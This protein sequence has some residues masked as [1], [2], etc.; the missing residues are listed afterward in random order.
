MRFGGVDLPNALSDA[1]AKGELVIFAG[2]GVSMASPSD[3]PDFPTLANDLANG[4]ATLRQD[5]DVD[6]F[7]GKL[8]ENLNIYERTRLRLSDPSSKPNSL[9][10]DLLRVFSGHTSVRLVTT[11][12][13]DHF[14][15]A[16]VEVFSG[17]CPELFYAPALPVGNNFNGIVH[18]HGSTRKDPRR[19]VL[20]DKDFGRAYLT[21]GWA[22]RFIQDL[23]LS[24]TV[25]FVGY[26]HNDP[27]M[28]YLAR[29]LPPSEFGRRRFAL[30][31]DEPGSRSSWGN[32][33][34][35]PIPYS[36][37]DGHMQLREACTKWAELVIATPLE[38]LQ[39][40]REIVS[41]PPQPAGED[42][43][44]IETALTDV[45][46]LRF[47]K[48]HAS[49]VAWLE[50]VSGRDTFKQLFN[51]E[52]KA[53]K[54]HQELAHWFAHRFCVAHAAIALDIVRRNGSTL[55]PTLW[56]EIARQ[57]WMG[58]K[59]GDSASCLDRWVP[60]LI[61]NQPSRGS[62]FLEYILSECRL[63]EDSASAILL[64]SHLVRPVI[65]LTSGIPT[66]K[67]GPDGIT[68][69]EEPRVMIE[70]ES[71]GDHTFLEAAW[72]RFVS[73]DFSKHVHQL[74]SIVV[75]HLEEATHLFRSYG[76][77]H[78]WWDPISIHLPD[79]ETPNIVLSHS[80]LAVL[81]KAALDS[82][83]WI[84]QKEP[85]CGTALILWWSRGQSITLR[86]IALLSVALTSEWTAD[87]KL[88]WL[89]S[90][91]LI[92]QP[93]FYA[94]VPQVLEAA[95]PG[96]AAEVQQ[97]VVD[98]IMEGPPQDIEPLHKQH[99]I[100]SLLSRLNACCPD[101]SGVADALT[102]IARAHPELRPPEA[103]IEIKGG[104]YLRGEPPWVT[105][106]FSTTSLLAL[107]AAEA[108]DQVLAFEPD[109]TR[110]IG[111][112]DVV[113]I[114]QRAAEAEPKWGI[115][116][117]SLLQQRGIF[118]TY[119]WRGIIAGLAQTEVR[120]E[121]WSVVLNLLASHPGIAEV[122][123]YEVAHLLEQG[124]SRESGGIPH[125]ELQLAAAV[126]RLVWNGLTPRKWPEAQSDDW[127]FTAINDP[128]GIIMQFEIRA[129]NRLWK[130]AGDGW[131]GI[132]AD[133]RSHWQNVIRDDSWTSAM[134]RT[135]LASQVHV[136]FAMDQDWTSAEMPDVFAWDGR[137][138]AAEQAW[139]G[140]LGWGRWSDEFLKCFLS[141]YTATFPYL[142]SNLGKHRARFCEH[143][144]SIAV[145]GAKNPLSDGWLSDFIRTVDDEDRA[146]W[147][148]SVEMALRQVPSD[149]KQFVWDKWMKTYWALRNQGQPL[150]PS[151]LEVSLMTHWLLSLGSAMPEAL[152]LL[153]Q[154]PK[155]VPRDNYANS[156]LYMR[157]NELRIDA[158]YPQEVA[159]F[160]RYLLNSETGAPYLD[161]INAVV[162]RLVASVADR[163]VL[164]QVCERLSVLG[165]PT[166]A[167]ELKRLVEPSTG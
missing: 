96:A 80:G 17:S 114:L 142:R 86:R 23:F 3:L 85:D 128:A 163:T 56:S 9:H 40:V 103:L 79:L 84:V 130:G 24:F 164:I 129:L 48:E 138:V 101:H 95:F 62:D 77:E 99:R 35:H 65:T 67:L 36:A 116:I 154:G 83:K 58:M 127:L 8:P 135:L 27:V 44:L 93:G 143:I 29:G 98:R 136:L 108:L 166:E 74:I 140:Y 69:L 123:T 66:E 152:Q 20:T 92:Y 2:A 159:L 147:A 5:E 149:K 162:R 125:E 132:P 16:A 25:L 133:W 39:R 122:A 28:H 47:F 4:I 107:S 156:S 146:S 45:V 75:A 52:I 70:C 61:A 115:E 72:Q 160:L 10:R 102:A 148:S 90:N 37:A 161:P 117:A 34:I 118:G 21:E 157:L 41:Q 82:F 104:A 43:D 63:P 71:H 145:F 38:K 76:L 32:R 19:M 88:S 150:L 126:G 137:L 7:L 22:R 60:L 73:N 89:L 54:C 121:N 113:A 105:P 87:D 51:H 57:L 131:T 50:W 15:S 112:D 59:T 64:F 46:L 81:V 91:D 11:N 144:A 12:F 109:D 13:D 6:R 55:P 68:M 26:S 151:G 134:G 119:L 124:V 1:Q 155:P 78:D 111:E 14:A 141:C 53:T 165:H 97:R 120:A 110:D 33:G 158:Q 49:S 167:A 42:I 100:Y 18:V 30:A 31:I 106:P 139:H 94:E 153:V